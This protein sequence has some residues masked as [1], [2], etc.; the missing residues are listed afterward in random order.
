MFAACYIGIRT[1]ACAV[2]IIAGVGTI[3]Y[4]G[5]VF[6][7]A[8]LSPAA[9]PITISAREFRCISGR[10]RVGLQSERQHAENGICDVS[11]ANWI[12]I[13]GNI[14][15]G[16]SDTGITVAGNNNR[17]E[18]NYVTQA[19][20]TAQSE[21]PCLPLPIVNNIIIKNT[22]SAAANNY[23]L[24][25]AQIVGPFITNTVSGIITNSN[26]WANFSF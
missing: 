26:P 17:I 10:H 22:V 6:R 25:G 11:R 1:P 15:I 24:P 23:S 16:N 19:A 8:A 3:S 5:P 21:S 7:V 18:D 13:I 4:S 9:R 2:L 20:F 14:C 12:A